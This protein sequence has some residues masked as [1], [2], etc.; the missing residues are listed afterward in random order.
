MNKLTEF[1]KENYLIV[2]IGLFFYSLFLYY[3]IQGNRLCD[4][5]STENYRP[6]Q[7]GHATV[8]RFYHK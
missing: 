7:N 3:T 4:C 8:N 5:E 2:L 1:L 6:T